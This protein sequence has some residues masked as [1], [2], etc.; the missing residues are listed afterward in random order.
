M[1]EQRV[2]GWWLIR[3]ALTIVGKKGLAELRRSSKDVRRAQEDVLRSFLENSKDTVYGREHNFSGI[4][5]SPGQNIF[6]AYRKN[7][8]INDYEDLR[9]YVERH[10][11]GEENILFPGKPKMYGTTSG[12][13]KEPKWIPITERYYQDVYKKLNQM[14]FYTL[15][16]NKPKVF[17]GMTLSIVGK[18]VEGAAPDGTLYG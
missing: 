6:E 18:A 3:L 9:P 16:M 15:I 10:K 13:T 1:K 12:T 5:E 8:P 2:K 11:N 17:Y 7:V 4:L 14:W